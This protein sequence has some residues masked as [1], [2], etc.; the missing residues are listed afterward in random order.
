M[1]KKSVVGAAVTKKDGKYYLF[2]GANDIHDDTKEIGGI[3]VAV[4]NKPEGPFKDYLGK[5]LIGKIYNKAQPIDQ[6][7]F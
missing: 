5:P 1:G 3:G 4:A 2:F 7:V 6:F